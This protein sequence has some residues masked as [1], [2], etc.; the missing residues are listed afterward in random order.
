MMLSQ[1]VFSIVRFRHSAIQPW[2]QG[3]DFDRATYIAQS[4]EGEEG[5]QRKIDGLR[6]QVIEV[7]GWPQDFHSSQTMA[8]AVLWKFCR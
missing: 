7:G 2:H 6:S 3:L 1:T 4:S 8:N 5:I